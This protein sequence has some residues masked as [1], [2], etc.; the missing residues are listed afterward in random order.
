MNGPNVEHAVSAHRQRLGDIYDR[1]AWNISNGMDPE[2]AHALTDAE[3][4][5]EEA[6]YLKDVEAAEAADATEP[7]E[8]PAVG[9]PIGGTECEACGCRH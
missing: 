9:A 4:A 8:C 2:Q 5:K 1:N 6:I 3:I 7:Q